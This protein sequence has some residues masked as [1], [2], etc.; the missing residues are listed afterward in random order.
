MKVLKN[1]LRFKYIIFVLFIIIT[2]LRANINVKS[3]YNINDNKFYGVVIDYKINDDYVS[4]VIKG[5]EKIKC[6]YYLSDNEVIDIKY[7]DKVLLDGTLSIPKNN[8]IPNTFNYKKYLNNNNIYYLLT[9][10]N[11]ISVERSKNIFYKFKNIIK[12]RIDNIDKSGYLEAFIMGNKSN[13]DKNIFNTYK[14]NG[15]MHIFSVSGMH[16]SILASIVLYLLN[17]V[18]RSENNIFFVIIVLIF[19]MILTNY[20]ASIVRSVVFFSLLKILK[21]LKINIDNKDILLIAISIILIIYPKYLYNIG[22]LY[23]SII[24]FSLI[25]YSNYFNRKYILNTILI[26]TVSLLIS[27]PITIN[28]NYFVN[29]FSILLNVFFVPVISFIV[30][31]LSIIIFF[32]PFFYK[33]FIILISILENISLYFDSI[34]FLNL[35]IC[36]MNYFVIFIYYLFLYLFLSKNRK[37][38]ILVLLLIIFLKVSIYFDINYYVYYLDVGQG[39]MSLVK[40]KDEV[41]VIDTGPKNFY[42]DYEIMDNIILF[43]RSIGV[44]NIDLL[45]ISHGDNDHIGNANYLINNFKVKN[46]SFNSGKYNEL[47]TDLIKLLKYKNINYFKD[48][49]RKYNNKIS[50]S[51]LNTKEYDNENDNS[52]VIY[53]KIYKYSFLFMGDAG[54]EKEKDILDLYSLLNVDFL[55]VGHHG[56]NTSSSREFIDVVKPRYSI[57]SVGKNNRY[58]HPK[59][60]VLNNLKKSKIYRT[61]KDGSII[62]RIKNNKIKIETCSP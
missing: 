51:Y 6:N 32:I 27:L 22:F 37:Y 59:E 1:L 50:Y 52:S 47:E 29:L 17:L 38:I 8:T 12:S 9:V 20:Q 2:L 21:Y 16:I 58:G 23:S 24:S 40:Y 11:V 4:F 26:S 13:I 55:K 56:S 31:P 15:V 34:K 7:G 19:Y 49:F 25:F 43:F 57:I 42:S 45:I 60:E 35:Y 18:N 14:N 48:T 5:R 3:K 41:I 53:L 30:Y 36:K 33:V 10:D 61:D 54:V 46:V 39:D 62:F 44:S 28:T